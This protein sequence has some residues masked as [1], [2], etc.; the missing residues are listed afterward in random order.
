LDVYVKAHVIPYA[1]D[2]RFVVLT[3]SRVLTGEGQSGDKIGYRDR[4]DIVCKKTGQG[5]VFNVYKTVLK[6]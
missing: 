2:I 1:R 5:P 4:S 3:S 6:K